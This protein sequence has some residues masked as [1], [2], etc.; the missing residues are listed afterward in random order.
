MKLNTKL[1]LRDPQQTELGRNII[2]HSIRLIDQ[3]GFEEFT[4]K[5]LAVVINSTEASVYRYF[6]NKH[7]LLVY[8]VSW[9]W[10]WLEY[11]IDFSTNNITSP[12]Q[13]LDIIIRIIAESSQDDPNIAHIEEGILH[14]IVISEAAKVYLTKHVD[15]ENKE[16]YFANYNSL[17]K[18]I[19]S[20]ISELN[21]SYSY[22]R[23]LASN[24]IET[25]QEQCFFSE[26]LPSLTEIKASRNHKGIQEFLK[27]I[28]YSV[29]G[30]GH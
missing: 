24:L 26:H 1:Y 22:P 18:K 14:R 17:C 9:Y 11:R 2:S 7:N 13:K 27:H 4:F 8:L 3:L 12:Q 30:T 10:A 20:V 6:E 23:A 25:A 29:L 28:A 16:G 5:K 15:K 21:P 19:A